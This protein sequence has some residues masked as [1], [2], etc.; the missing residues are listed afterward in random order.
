M[1]RPT[2]VQKDK[3]INRSIQ[4][5]RQKR[6]KTKS[7]AI[8]KAQ[9][10]QNDS[11]ITGQSNIKNEG[12]NDREQEKCWQYTRKCLYLH[13]KLKIGRKRAIISSSLSTGTEKDKPQLLIGAVLPQ[14]NVCQPQRFHRPNR[15][16]W[17]PPCHLEWKQPNHLAWK[18]QHQHPRHL[19]LLCCE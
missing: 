12:E 19:Q 3:Y 5:A 18:Y 11:A 8:Q 13:K 1:L 17:S 7:W 2:Q 16:N 4:M 9:E 10:K 15:W 14:Q 6:R